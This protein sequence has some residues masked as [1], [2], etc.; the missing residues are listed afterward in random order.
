MTRIVFIIYLIVLYTSQIN[1]QTTVWPNIEYAYAKA[2]MYNLK[3]NLHGEYQIVKND[4]IDKT[5]TSEGILLTKKQTRKVIMLSGKD[6]K[7]LN[8]GLSACFIPHH[9][10]VFFSKNNKPVASVMLAFDCESM[11]LEPVKKTPKLNRE[12]TEKEIE[13]QLVILNEYEQLIKEL[14][15][16]VFESP[17][18]YRNYSKKISRNEAYNLKLTGKTG[19]KQLKSVDS[20]RFDLSGIALYNNNVFV[21]ADKKWNNR[22]YRV[23]TTFNTFTIKPIIPICTDDKIDFEG[24]AVCGEQIYLIEEWLDNA[25]KLNPDSCKLEKLELKWE[26]YGIYRSGWGN[27]GLEGLAVDCENNILYLAKERQPRRLFEI[28]LK[29][30]EITEPFIETLGP[31]KAGFDISDM[32]FENGYLYILERGRGLVTRINTETKEKLSYSFQQTVLNDGKRIFDNRN[33]EYG[34]A[35]ALLLTKDQIWIGIDNNGD[36]VSEYGK[37]LGLKENN[38]TV[39]LIFERPEGF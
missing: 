16:S 38:N 11:R 13:E 36:P 18:A 10:I 27:M 24:I 28:D 22:I 25:Y 2:Y 20:K 4:R 21:V 15:F 5:A 34:M 17:S 31:Q 37:K 9:A 23:D 35:E 8:A 7:G 14:G 30:G 1:A 6:V 19:V 12:L 3:S 39:I 29:L 26:D 33:P 32:K